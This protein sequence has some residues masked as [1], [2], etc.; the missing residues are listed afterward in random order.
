MV[1][2][3]IVDTERNKNEPVVRYRS[4]IGKICKTMH[5][6]KENGKMCRGKD[7]IKDKQIGRTLY[8][9]SS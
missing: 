1:V 2:Y 7:R 4:N 3:E 8:R 6:R 9:I 5:L